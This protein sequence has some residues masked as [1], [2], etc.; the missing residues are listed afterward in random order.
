MP[1][2]RILLV[3]DEATNREILTYA[4]REEGYVVD[5]VVSAGAATLC[6]ELTPYALV[7]ADWLLPDGSGGDVADAAAKLGAKTF[8]ISGH[9]RGLPDGAAARHEFLTKRLGP[10]EIVAAVRQAIGGPVDEAPR[11][12][13]S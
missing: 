11:S 3:E 1:E 7:I 9:I 2:K 12:D 13:P 10:T 5:A 8:I 4:L 6:L